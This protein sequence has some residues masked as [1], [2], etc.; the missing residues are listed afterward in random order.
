MHPNRR[1]I[2]KALASGA[3]ALS[4]GLS[5]TP[6]RAQTAE[7]FPK[8][9]RLA[10]PGNATG[11][12]YGSGPF[13]VLKAKELL[14]KEFEKEGITFSWQFPRGTGPAINEAFANGQ[15][16]VASYG[17]LPNIVG[18]GAGLKTRVLASYGTSPIYLVA[19]PSSGIKTIADLKGK[20]LAV[21]RG[22][23][24][25][26]SLFIILKQAGLTVQDLQ[27]FDLQ[28][29]DQ[30]SAITTGDID[31]IVAGGSNVLH[32]VDKGIAE[33]VYSTK[34]KL[35]PGTTFGS[36]IVT[37]AFAEKYPHVVKRIVKNYVEAAHY[38]SQEENRDE[39]FDLWSL[40]GTPR[41]SFVKDYDGDRLVDR[42]SPL[43]DDFYKANVQAGIDFAAGDK[44]I[45]RAFDLNE[46]IDD[47]YL[48]EV[49]KELGYENYWVARKADGE[50]VE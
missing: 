15:L 27:V 24:N 3:L 28:S 49:L 35:A 48:N 2:F 34:G 45:R 41:E 8:E 30:I 20:K 47:S 6:V 1:G 16:D 18:R 4:V 21:A 19:T 40:T 13:G 46:W 36:L 29:A 37:D 50:P 43:L 42:A 9:I 33:V 23:I 25:E 39:L 7:E 10:A 22:T 32:L 12:P 31:A 44:L 26:L 38:A 14:E 5:F 11:K 17:G